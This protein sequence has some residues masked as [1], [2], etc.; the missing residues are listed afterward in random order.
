[1][2]GDFVRALY[3]NVSTPF[4]RVNAKVYRLLRAPKTGIHKL[5]LGPGQKHYLPGWINVDANIISAKI[6]VW[7]DLR[8]PLPF[9]D[10]TMDCAYSHHVVEHIGKMDDH[11]HEVFRVL[12]PGGVY[13]VAGPDAD[14]AIEMF[15]AGNGSWFGKFPE[16]RASIG[17]KLD[18]FIICGRHHF[19]LLTKSFITEL[20]ENAGFTD[21]SVHI[22][23]KTSSRMDLFA[24]AVAKEHEDNFEFPHTLVIEA[25]KPKSA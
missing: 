21:V 1:M 4:M 23:T 5:H 9:H 11:F 2:I 17:G 13:R 15:K 3:W 14:N 12:K 25:V 7:A 16:D 22:P 19:A 6:D 20:L 8:A 24:D 10:G 18:N